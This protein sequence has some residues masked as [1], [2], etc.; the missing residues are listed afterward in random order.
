M[1]TGWGWNPDA[2]GALGSAAAA[3][4]AAI[5]VVIAACTARIALRVGLEARRLQ[6]EVLNRRAVVAQRLLVPEAQRIRAAVQSLCMIASQ[7]E[8]VDI[9]VLRDAQGEIS[10]AVLRSCLDSPE[11]YSME[12]CIAMADVYREMVMF[13]DSLSLLN[14]LPVMDI[15]LG[16]QTAAK[17]VG[18]LAALKKLEDQLQAAN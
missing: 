7:D 18:L 6:E 17:S 8:L 1:A 2:L 13:R 14:F 9:Q 10:S 15:R 5:G 12:L 16:D 11:A 4:V 3:V